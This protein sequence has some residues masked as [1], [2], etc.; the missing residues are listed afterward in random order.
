MRAIARTG[1]LALTV[2]TFPLT[3]SGARGTRETQGSLQLSPCDIPGSPGGARCG[4]FDVYE[5]RATAKGRRVGLNVVV[6]PASGPGPRKEPVFWLEGGPGGA[7]TGAIGPVS[8]QYLRGV[9]TDRDLVFVDQRGTGASNPLNCDLGESPADLDRYYGPIFPLD[10]VR[11]CR[12]TLE[13]IADLTQYT[14]S[15]AADDLDDVREALGYPTINL[16]GASY[17]TQAAL[18]YMRRHRDRV[19]SAFLVG[20]AP[21]DF[22]LPLPF[23]RAAQHALDLTLADCAADPSCRAAFPDVKREFDAVLARFDR[24]PLHVT[25]TDPGTGRPRSVALARESYVEHLRLQ[26]YNTFGARTIPVVI[27]QAFLGNFVPF[28]RVAATIHPSLGRGMYLS[29]TCSEDTPFISDTDIVEQTR[30]T[31]LGDRRLRAHIAAC[32]EWPRAAVPQTFLDPVRSDAPTV[33][34]SG[35]ADGSTPLWIAEAAVRFLANGRLI[36]VPHTGHQITGACAWN[37]MRDFIT[38][39]DVRTLD[40]TCVAGAKRPTFAID[41]PS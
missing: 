29:V 41:P 10:L 2:L 33:L 26:L 8:Q 22:K 6:L 39:P 31:F 17:G 35:E 16:A 12:A 14:T 32:A 3:I 34:Y 38:R 5:N 7:A 1:L 25:M 21:P 11:A 37:L 19:R 28:Q 20:V 27:H 15:A 24:G 36:Q 30:G 23:A 40:A 13:P 4:R 9:R 18:V